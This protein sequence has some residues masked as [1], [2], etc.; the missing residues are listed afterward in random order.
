VTFAE[1]MGLQEAI[2]LIQQWNLQNT[3]IEMD[4]KAMVDAFHRSA[5]PRTIWGNIV[6]NCAR[7]V[8]ERNDVVVV[9]TRRSGNS[10]A[11]DLAK[12]AE[13]EPNRDWKSNFPSCITSY[14]QKDMGLASHS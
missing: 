2:E 7:K 12:W 6:K 1:A 4:A 3:I 11:H 9:W 5:Q 10:A 14:I 13:T 8:K